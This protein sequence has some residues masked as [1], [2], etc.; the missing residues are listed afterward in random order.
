MNRVHESFDWNRS[1]FQSLLPVGFLLVLA[2][3]LACCIS[4]PSSAYAGNQQDAIAADASAGVSAD[5]SLSSTNSV[6][7]EDALKVGDNGGAIATVGVGASIG[8]VE[9]V[10]EGVTTGGTA[11]TIDTDADTATTSTTEQPTTVDANA[12]TNTVG[13]ATEGTT[14]SDVSGTGDAPSPGNADAAT[15]DV[16][17]P[18]NAVTPTGTATGNAD[19]ATGTAPSTTG[20]ETLG[21][22]EATVSAAQKNASAQSNPIQSLIVNDVVFFNTTK[23]DHSEVFATYDMKTNTLTLLKEAISRIIARNLGAGFTILAT[24]THS[25]TNDSGDSIDVQ[26]EL[27][28]DGTEDTTITLEGLLVTKEDE[29]SYDGN[30][31]LT[32]RNGKVEVKSKDPEGTT[33]THAPADVAGDVEVQNKASLVVA[34]ATDYSSALHVGGDLLISDEASLTVAD[35][36]T[37]N[38]SSTVDVDG[39]V[40]FDSTG[41]ITL[42]NPSGTG[43]TVGKNL[44]ITQGDGTIMGMGGNAILVEN[45]KVYLK[46]GAFTILTLPGNTNGTE[47]CCGIYIKNGD[48]VVTGGSNTVLNIGSDDN[49]AGILIEKVNQGVGNLLV[50]DGYLMV[51]AFNTGIT[52]PDGFII[53]NGGQLDSVGGYVGIHG[54]NIVIQGG[55]VNAFATGKADVADKEALQK[56]IAEL[57]KTHTPEEYI[58]ILQQIGVLYSESTTKGYA[59]IADDT[60]YINGGTVTA[61]AFNNGNLAHSSAAGNEMIAIHAGNLVQIDG[62]T[63]VAL[64]DTDGTSST[65][66]GIHAG[67]A[68]QTIGTIK[69]SGGVVTAYA[70][71]NAA[72]KL[73]LF[74]EPGNTNSP[75][76]NVLVAAA[77]KIAAGTR[78]PGV[79]VDGLSSDTIY[80]PYLYITDGRLYLEGDYLKWDYLGKSAVLVLVGFDPP[81]GELKVTRE[82]MDTLIGLNRTVAILGNGTDLVV[83]GDWL[84]SVIQGG[85]RYKLAGGGDL[86]NYGEALSVLVKGQG[87]AF[88]FETGQLFGGKKTI[89]QVDGVD[90]Y[91]FNTFYNT[92]PE[93]AEFLAMVGD[94]LIHSIRFAYVG[95]WPADMTIA[96]YIGPDYAGQTVSWYYRDPATGELVLIGDYTVNAIGW[97]TATTQQVSHGNTAILTPAKT[98][99]ASLAKAS[100]SPKTG[101]TPIA[102]LACLVLLSLGGCVFAASRKGRAGRT[103]LKER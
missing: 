46:G 78:A 90:V 57:Q 86:Q 13:K 1:S 52:V 69:I 77:M 62:G 24:G 25:F 72:T 34:G 20:P 99:T 48:M 97:I 95:E 4:L 59:L 83:P 2:F 51:V 26:G 53:V 38:N 63:V 45:G 70:F 30:G 65:S 56:L 93:H 17:S 39:N 55:A 96:M 31:D 33:S 7:T 9:E 67:Q 87:V 61:M 82:M 16:P 8:A 94:R 6:T 71:D 73:A 66:I 60:I 80:S 103:S 89:H 102:A 5:V 23:A 44:T 64:A 28:F 88:M 3:M 76:G 91:D 37:G 100:V 79:Q 85:I 40:E 22:A 49:D 42:V 43:L 35:L 81:D 36:T 74:S 84:G 12:S 47:P 58:A 29:E 10:A 21:T 68:G 75:I 19:A 54:K 32:I 18:G 41:H 27:V 11:S 15:G 50:G 92:D 98:I 101:D 14:I